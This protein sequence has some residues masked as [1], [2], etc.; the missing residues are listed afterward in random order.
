MSQKLNN[1]F[2]KLIKSFKNDSYSIDLLL[3]D[4]CDDHDDINEQQINNEINLNDFNLLF[5]NH[6][7]ELSNEALDENLI[8]F[9]YYKIKDLT[10]I[11]LPYID[12]QDHELEVKRALLNVISLVNAFYDFLIEN[13][14]TTVV[15]FNQF[16]SFF[17]VCIK[18][19]Y[20]LINLLQRSQPME[21]S[22]SVSSA[23]QISSQFYT[24]QNSNKFVL[25]LYNQINDTLTLMI[26][27]FE[28]KFKDALNETSQKLIKLVYFTLKIISIDFGLKTSLSRAIWKIIIKIVHKDKIFSNIDMN[29][30]AIVTNSTTQESVKFVFKKVFINLY[31]FCYKHLRM[32]RTDL[33]F[34]LFPLWLK[35]FI[36]F[37]KNYAQY[38]NEP[39]DYYM[40]TNLFSITSFLLLV[41]ESPP[42]IYEKSNDT[43]QCNKNDEIFDIYVNKKNKIYSSKSGKIYDEIYSILEKLINNYAEKL[44][45]IEFIADLNNVDKHRNELNIKLRNTYSE[46][47]I[48]NEPI[49]YNE[50]LTLFLSIFM[51]KCS[52][53]MKT[54]EIN[55][56]FLNNIFDR[57]NWCNRACNLPIYMVSFNLFNNDFTELSKISNDNHSIIDYYDL[58]QNYVYD[59]TLNTMLQVPNA[60]K[61]L[62]SYFIN[63]QISLS[64][65]ELKVNTNNRLNLAYDVLLLLIKQTAFVQSH[66][67]F[68]FFKYLFEIFEY[69]K[70]SYKSNQTFYFYSCLTQG[71]EYYYSKTKKD[72]VC[73]LKLLDYLKEQKYYNSCAFI[74]SIIDESINLK[75][76][77]SDS[78]FSINKLIDNYSI[79]LKDLT[80]FINNLELN[81]MNA[82]KK[83]ITWIQSKNGVQLTNSFE[84]LIAKLNSSSIGIVCECFYNLFCLDFLD[85]FLKLYGSCVSTNNEQTKMIY[86]FNLKFLFNFMFNLIKA[87]LD[88]SGLSNNDSDKIKLFNFL[89]KYSKIKTKIS[90]SDEFDLMLILL[91][92]KILTCYAIRLYSYSSIQIKDISLNKK[93]IETLV[94]LADDSNLILRA[95]LIDY[96]LGLMDAN[97]KLFS[98]L[99]RNHK[100][101]NELLDNEQHIDENLE[102]ILK[103]RDEFYFNEFKDRFNQNNN[104]NINKLETNIS[105]LDDT[106]AAMCMDFTI[107]NTQSSKIRSSTE[108]SI[109]K[110]E[111]DLDSIFE[112]YINEDKPVW[113]RDRISSLFKIYSDKI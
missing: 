43:S 67:A 6:L 111:K 70:S 64:K 79:F 16:S 20:V 3:E 81:D 73:L 44:D 85:S 15:E 80:K 28:T 89:N 57:I 23:S 68:K 47:E 14:E 12:D 69:L 31:K 107:C 52:E 109:E 58:I 9:I 94:I 7:K 93:I 18:S 22:M 42:L 78:L 75:R 46:T 108:K 99:I 105:M 33:D 82:L 65:Q 41:E 21:I 110:I 77:P 36:V 84:C 76:N 91:N 17:I 83:L 45:Y 96:L 37:V 27:F 98:E 106:M 112:V 72:N 59:Y 5:K 61:Y 62:L 24:S 88:T 53:S 56:K 2:K 48:L 30:V 102:E 10:R 50:E 4:D 8:G 54:K 86:D 100:N 40:I 49:E 55:Y 60:N 29:Q 35:K 25:D 97:S 71:F 66:E 113:L 101:I 104:N 63:N 87:W 11:I 39:E 13:N 92:F 1:D 51:N 103:N 95:C 34:K 38:L 90:S 32:V 74:T 19:I 26:K